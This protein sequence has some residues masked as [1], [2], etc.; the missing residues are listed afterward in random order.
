MLSP[1]FSARARDTCLLADGIQSLS[2]T[3]KLCEGNTP[4]TT[5]MALSWALID[6]III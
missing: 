3:S 1:L 6:I 2:S 5:P 4:L